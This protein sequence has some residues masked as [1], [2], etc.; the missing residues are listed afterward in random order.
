[1]TKNGQATGYDG[2][3][4]HTHPPGAFFRDRLLD[5]SQE[6]TN[7]ERHVFGKLSAR[8]FQRIRFGGGHRHDSICRDMEHGKPA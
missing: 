1:M 8:C 5:I 7:T 2:V 3:Y 6:G 4:N